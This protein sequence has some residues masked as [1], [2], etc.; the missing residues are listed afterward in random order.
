MHE[1]LRTFSSMEIRFQ[2]VTPTDFAE[3]TRE[4]LP[5]VGNRVR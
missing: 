3:L 4:Y 2:L 5:P 1:E